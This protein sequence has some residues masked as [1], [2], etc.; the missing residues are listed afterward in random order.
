M[1]NIIYYCH[2]SHYVFCYF[3]VCK[4]CTLFKCFSFFCVLIALINSHNATVTLI[5]FSYSPVYHDKYGPLH[6]LFQL[7]RLVYQ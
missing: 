6:T 2:L 7:P 3:C 4:V 1:Y 5:I